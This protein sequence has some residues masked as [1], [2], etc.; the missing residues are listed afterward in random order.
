VADPLGERKAAS[1]GSDQQQVWAK[2]LDIDADL[3]A[4]VADPIGR[5]VRELINAWLPAMKDEW[6]STHWHWDK[7]YDMARRFIV[8]TIGH[9]PAWPLTR[10]Q[11]EA[12][13]ATATAKS[14]KGHTSNALGAMLIW[15]HA[16]EWGAEPPRAVLPP[17]A[18]DREV[19][20]ESPAR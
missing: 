4:A 5:T 3:A 8:P 14:A 6:A 18:A 20:E 9:L 10:A 11:V 15:G 7:C 2:A 1:G 19:V 17:A 16:K 13:V 12:V